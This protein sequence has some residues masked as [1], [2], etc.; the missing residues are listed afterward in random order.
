[1]SS[2][3]DGILADS[4][5]RL[6]ERMREVPLDEVQRR[7]ADAPRADVSFREALESKPFS[8]IAEVKAKSPSGGAMD[9]ANIDAALE[10]YAETESVSAVSILTDEK[11]FGGSLER[12]RAARQRTRKPLLRKD[13]IVNE[14]QVWEA[15]AHGADAVLLMA[16][17]YRDD[18]A[19]L[20]RI[21]D[22]VR[23]LGMAA[24]FELGMR[25]V[26]NPAAVVPPHAEIWGINSRRF[27]TTRLQLRSRVGRLLGARKFLGLRTELSINADAHAEL[28]LQ[29]PQGKIAIAES[30]IHDRADLRRLFD[31]NYRSALIGT[32]FLKKGAKVAEVVR[33]FD[34]EARRMTLAAHPGPGFASVPRTRTA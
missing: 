14:Y 24:L 17:L 9:P 1:M 15:R 31:L 5:K 32:A 30:G 10:I 22:L 28:R 6:D 25:T 3:I 18:P 4:R 29:I 23:S 19:S 27:D 11:H 7:A 12:L 13:F 16:D 33:A 34:E 21:F 8:I 26:A 2:L 20:A